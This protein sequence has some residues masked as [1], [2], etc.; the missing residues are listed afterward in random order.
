MRS[1]MMWN[2]AEMKSWIGLD[3]IEG[4]RCGDDRIGRMRVGIG[5]RRGM[6][7]IAMRIGKRL[8]SFVDALDRG[9]QLQQMRGYGLPRC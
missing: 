4:K 6:M 3:R 9:R 5:M 1:V 8:S 7:R 2:T